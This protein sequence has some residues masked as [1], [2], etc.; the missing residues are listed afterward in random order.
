L[1]LKEFKKGLSEIRF[2]KEIHDLHVWSLSVGKPAMSAHILS[3]NPS[4]TLKSAT[5]Y[6]R[7]YGIY[8]STL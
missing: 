6:C 4:K 8:H 2:V 3:S 5:R 7:K 1:D